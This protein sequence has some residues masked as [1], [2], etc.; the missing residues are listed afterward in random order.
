MGFK[1]LEKFNEA[2]LAKQVWR[3][4]I[5]HTS[6]FY[7]VFNAKYFP[8]GS[9]LDAKPSLGS[10]AWQSIVKA[11]PLIKLS[12]LWRVGDGK[13]MKIFRERWLPGEEPA[14]VISPLNSISTEWIVSRLLDPTGVGWNDQFVD[15]MFLPFEAQ[16]I[17]GI[18]ICVTIQEDCVSWPKCRIGSYSVRS[19]YQLFCE[20]EA[21]GA[22]S[23]ST[24]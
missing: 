6:L 17:K 2:M 5:D 20:V 1:D 16:R 14:K 9:F 24:D 3:L 10:Y 12:M 8:N 15:A 21:T 19:K 22:P 7:R 4:L 18:P 11:I 23:G 13:Q